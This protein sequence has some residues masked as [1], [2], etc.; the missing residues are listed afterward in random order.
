[1]STYRFFQDCW[2]G[3]NY[4]VAGS[5]AA[6]AD[7]SATATVP[8][9]LPVGWVPNSRACE[10][11][12][13]PA[14]NAFYA[15]PVLVPGLAKQQFST[16]FPLAPV[17]YWQQIVNPAGGPSKYVLTGLGASLAPIWE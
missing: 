12:D 16:I 13:T 8:N 10:P 7:V 9:T 17:T 11:M 5:S 4:Y 6:T 2:I 14:L 15:A 1:M 3:T